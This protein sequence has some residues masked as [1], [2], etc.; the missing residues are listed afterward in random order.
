[1]RKRPVT[2]LVPAAALLLAGA[3]TL[4][5]CGSDNNA[6]STG[7]NGSGAQSATADGNQPAGITGADCASGTLTADGSTAQQNAMTQWIKDY[8]SKCSGATLTYGGGG[9][10]QGITDFSNG[11]VDFAGSDAPLSPAAGEV[12][13]ATKSCG[14]QAVDLPMVTGPIAVAYHLGG[15]SKLILTADEI[16]KIFTGKITTWND[17]PL[18]ASNPGVKLPSAK[19]TV[20]TRSDASGTTQNFETYLGASAPSVWTQ[21]PSKQWDGT[22]QGKSGNQLVGQAIGSTKNSIG[23]VEWSYA[24]QNNLPTAEVDNGAGPVQLTAETAAKTVATAQVA[25]SGPGDLTLKLDYASK[26]PGA[27]PIVLVTYEVVCT[28]YRDTAT[29]TLVRSF[30][31]FV[32]GAAEQAAVHQLGYA[33]LPAGIASKVQAQIAKIS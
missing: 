16:A 6:T 17:A 20:F 33:A 13:A 21:Q 23:Y 22:G 10:G 7:G 31:K 24:I 26:V 25:P 30:M 32:A 11:Q 28:K 3:L 18:A 27:Y 9:S 14:S 12:A 4:S 15:V 1:M 5:A 2:K 19:I 29:G 8:Q